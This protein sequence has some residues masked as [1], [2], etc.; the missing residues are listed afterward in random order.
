MAQVCLAEDEAAVEKLAAQGADQALAS[1]V[2][3]RR[4]DGG[5]QDP[6]AG[7]LE[8]GVEGAGEVRA[9]VTD[10]ESE[11]LGPLA[12]VQG[13]VAGLLHGP[14]A[15]R[16]GGD[17]SRVH[18]AGAVPDEHQDVQPGQQHSVDME[19]SAVRIPAASACRNC[20]QVGPALCGAGSMPAARRIS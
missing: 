2:H 17:P 16:V 14:L 9:A 3:P 12:K 8:D 19:E 13:E 11:V 5:V 7:G 20:R 15:G 4:L 18:P 1:R 6:G 10:Q